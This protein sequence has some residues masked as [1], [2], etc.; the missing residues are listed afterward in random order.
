MI[1]LDGSV[2]IKYGIRLNPDLKYYDLKVELSKLCGIS[3]EQLL[4]CELYGSQIRVV[5]K[6]DQKIRANNSLDF[7]CY[8]LPKGYGR[9]RTSSEMG[10]NIEQGLKDIQR[11]QG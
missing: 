2:P 3:L 1:L 4:I 6:D 10:V 5:F 8:E 11:N 9:P 7:Y